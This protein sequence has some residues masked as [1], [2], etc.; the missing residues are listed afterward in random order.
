MLVIDPSVCIDCGVCVPE[1]PIQAIIPDTEPGADKWVELNQRLSKLW[2]VIT[3]IKEP[4]PH[5]DEWKDKKDKLP[6]LSEKPG[7]T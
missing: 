7:S 5:A 3:Q 1:C 2:P 6:W 4:L